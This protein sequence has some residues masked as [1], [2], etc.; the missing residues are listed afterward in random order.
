[1]SQY[2]LMI[3][4]PVNQMERLSQRRKEEEREFVWK[5]LISMHV[6]FGPQLSGQSVY[7]KLAGGEKARFIDGN[8]CWSWIWFCMFPLNGCCIMRGKHRG[9]WTTH[10]HMR[11]AG[12]WIVAIKSGLGF[13]FKSMS[14]PDLI[15]FNA[16]F[17]HSPFW[18]MQFGCDHQALLWEFTSTPVLLPV[19]P[20]GCFTRQCTVWQ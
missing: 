19:F 7:I 8:Q 3:Y 6:W 4:Y 14:E 11:S 5:Q 16:C 18:S 13:R 15:S 1:M 12:L 10:K 9:I 20:D 2:N 17:N